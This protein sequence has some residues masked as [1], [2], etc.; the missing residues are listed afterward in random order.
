MQYAKFSEIIDR[1]EKHYQLTLNVCKAQIDLVNFLDDLHTTIKLL[2]E[3]IYGQ[4][5]NGWIEW[6]LYE[7]PSKKLQAWDEQ[8]NPICDSVES[9]WTYLE[10][11]HKQK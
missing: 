9:L 4:E 2:F 5:G 3:E 7:N 8:G 6:W 1:L 10:E 11:N